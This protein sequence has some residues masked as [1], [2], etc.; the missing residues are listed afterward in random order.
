MSDR[1]NLGMISDFWCQQGDG[2]QKEK[3]TTDPSGCGLTLQVA[4][5]QR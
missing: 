5:G 2:A 4:G 3:E 1:E